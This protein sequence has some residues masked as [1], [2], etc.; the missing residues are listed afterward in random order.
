LGSIAAPFSSLRALKRP[1][2]HRQWHFDAA[3][4]MLIEAECEGVRKTHQAQIER[5][6]RS[7]DA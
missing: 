2:E 7:R 6:E 5:N 3:Q 4:V 1:N